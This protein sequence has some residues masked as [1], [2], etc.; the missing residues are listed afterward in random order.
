[1]SLFYSWSSAS[2]TAVSGYDNKM[3]VHDKRVMQVLNSIAWVV[4]ILHWSQWDIPAAGSERSER[5]VRSTC[6]DDEMQD[7]PTNI[8]DPQW[9]HNEIV[10]ANRGVLMAMLTNMWDLPAILTKMWDLTIIMTN[11]FRKCW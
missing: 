5:N 8:W 2:I 10:I 9:W 3:P 11:I 7:L 4:F 6:N 1:M